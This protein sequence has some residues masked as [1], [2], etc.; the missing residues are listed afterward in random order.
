VSSSCAPGRS[1]T[2]CLRPL[3]TTQKQ[4]SCECFRP[5]VFALH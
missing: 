2:T 1:T 3:E 5:V 4:S